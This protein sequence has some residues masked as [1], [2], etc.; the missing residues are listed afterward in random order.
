MNMGC[1][2]H[3]VI[4]QY[5]PQASGQ[6][7]KQLKGIAMQLHPTR[8][9]PTLISAAVLTLTACGGGG[10]GTTAGT[11]GGT[12]GGDTTNTVLTLSGVAATG[13]ALSS[14]T[15]IAKCATGTQTGT[16]TADGSY[17]LAITGGALPCVL[18]ASDGT[19]TLHSLASGEGSS[20]TAN[21]TP[22]TE[23]VVAQLSGQDPATFFADTTAGSA[24]IGNAVTTAAVSSAAEAVVQT[25]TAAGL[26]TTAIGNPITGALVAGSGSGYDG[27]LDT[28]GTTLA[29]SGST[30][31]ELASTVAAASPASAQTTASAADSSTSALAAELLL[32]PAASSCSSLRAG[33]YWAVFSS[34]TGGAAVQKFRISMTFGTP[35][36]TYFTSADGT[37]LQDSIHTLTGNGSCRFTSGSGDDIVV[38]PAGVLVG[39]TAATE[40]F[41][42]VPV[43]AHTLEELAGQWNL[44]GGDVADT[45]A[46][47]TGWT[48]GYA[49]MSISGSGSS[50]MEQLTQGCWFSATT[51][52]SC[53]EIDADTLALQRPVVMRS[54][55][56][57]T[58]HSANDTTDGGPWE[59]RFFV[60]KT[61][62][63]DYFA[64]GA[65]IATPD[66]S[67]DG[68]LSYATKVRTLSLP[69]L[70][71]ISSNWNLAFNWRSS[72]APSAI[73]A[74]TNTVTSV[75]TAAGSFTRQTGAFGS[76]AT[77]K[78][79]ILLNTPFAG[80]NFRDYV[81]SVP[82]NGGGTTAVRKS[83]FLK[84]GS[85]GVTVV[86][87]PYQDS[88]K[89][90]KLVVSVAQPAS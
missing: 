73:D 45:D 85:S 15:V 80:F 17:Q 60:Y 24:A 59:D 46:G 72:L 1:A 25:L 38:S 19:T 71:T 32:K 2:Q 51:L 22:V 41:V 23:L 52:S 78:Q 55:G 29:A 49:T 6:R 88:S 66:S 9:A 84:T 89:P 33:D 34:R 21:I 70:G 11:G 56:S 69:T 20:A 87:Q 14:A 3:T 90:A 82:V 40:A 67:G 53:T 10:G 4:L 86:L 8:W 48:Y 75:D 79:T 54:D 83:V 58:N 62:K 42:A 7:H 47:D 37:E 77:H 30:L 81:A 12:S 61:G 36:L 43:Q 39:R 68:S 76:T 26:D 50:G 65:N 63:G 18:E 64:I 31:D 13:A 16:T 35:A 74:N 44:I 5:A 28:L 27:V 57:F